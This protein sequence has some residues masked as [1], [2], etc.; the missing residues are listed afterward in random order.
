MPVSDGD[1]K[2]LIA[3]LRLSVPY[4]GLIITARETAQMRRE[5]LKLG[6]TQTDASTKIGIGAYSE[7]GS[8][9]EAERQQFILGDTRSLDEVI[10]EFADL[11]YITSFCTAGYRCGRT[12]QYIMELLRKGKE[13][14]FCKLNA[15][16]TFREWLND[17]APEKTKEKGE[18]IIKKEITEIKQ[19]LPDFFP[20]FIDYYE[21]IKNGSRDL[22]F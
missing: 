20:Q 2:K 14:W 6:I 21:K 8:Q 10:G 13:R 18:R 16:L 17:Y 5:A 3:V 11:G 19:N 22:Y 4:T 9:Q 12:G 1:F 7:S 15:V